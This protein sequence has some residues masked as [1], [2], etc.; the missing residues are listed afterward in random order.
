VNWKIDAIEIGELG[1][2]ILA[3]WIPF[4]MGRAGIRNPW[5]MLAGWFALALAGFAF[6]SISEF[7]IRAQ[8]SEL[9][10]SVIEGLMY[11]CYCC[12]AGHLLQQRHPS[13][14]K[15]CLNLYL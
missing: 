7:A 3:L 11:Y 6:L 4:R 8:D 15:V 5:P 14:E 10:N 13:D 2:L 1:L 9:V 12:S